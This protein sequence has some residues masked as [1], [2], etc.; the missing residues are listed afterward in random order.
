MPR[1]MLTNELWSKLEPMILQQDVYDKPN[2]RMTIEGILYRIRTGC[3]WRDL[4]LAFGDWC[5]IH[6][7]PL[8]KA[9]EYFL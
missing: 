4:P 7:L 5:A 6:E 8:T 9:T 2:L 3:P 1:L